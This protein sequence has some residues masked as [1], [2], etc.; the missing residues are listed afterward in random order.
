MNWREE[1]IDPA[2]AHE[3]QKHI[4]EQCAW[5]AKE[6]GNPHPYLNLAQL[7]R[8]ENRQDE[9][10]ALLLHAVHLDPAFAEAHAALTGIYAIRNDY[11]AAW[12]HARAAQNNGL[13]TAVDLLT[14]YQ[15]PE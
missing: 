14:K 10:L 5:I 3:T 13:T 6:P 9:A 1:L 11:K 15:I 8:I 2:L 12:A 7:Y 4:A